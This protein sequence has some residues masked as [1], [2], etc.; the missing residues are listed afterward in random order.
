[1]G[2]GVSV[3]GARVSNGLHDAGSSFKGSVT[4]NPLRKRKYDPAADVWFAVE[5]GDMDTVADK[6][7]KVLCVASGV[8]MVLVPV[9]TVAAAG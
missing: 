6:M 4:S 7:D 3:M 9:L 8:R 5:A 2:S 1:M